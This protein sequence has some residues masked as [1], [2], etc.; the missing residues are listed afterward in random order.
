MHGK[1][2]PVDDLVLRAQHGDLGAF[3]RLVRTHREA[4]G[5]LVQR[6]VGPRGD[7][8]DVVQEVL[9]QLHRALPSFRGDAKFT[10]WLHRL[11]VNVARMHLR[12]QR[13]RPRIATNEVPDAPRDSRPELDP[14]SEAERNA[15]VAAFHALLELLPEKK[16]E[17]I[18][19]HDLE[20]LSPAAIAEIVDAPIMTVRTRLFYARKELYAAMATDPHTAQ[21]VEALLGKLKGKPEGAP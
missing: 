5:R 9:I 12:A 3:D 7:V 16:R 18:V 1:A 13:S 14:E 6:F 2:T 20:G 15:R 10:T 11:T 8:E 21:I 17:V 4:I 19:L